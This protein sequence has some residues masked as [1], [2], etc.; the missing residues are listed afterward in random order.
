MM[1]LYNP[2][3]LNT[4]K[5]KPSHINEMGRFW[6][7]DKSGDYCIYLF[8]RSFTCVFGKKGE[9]E[10][11]LAHKDKIIKNFTG[12]EAAAVFRDVHKAGKLD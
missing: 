1:K 6:L 3:T 10:Y 12:F 2:L 7:V 8:E 11:L 9:K 5:D 4:K